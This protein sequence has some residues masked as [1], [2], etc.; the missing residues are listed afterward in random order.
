MRSRTAEMVK[1]FHV[2][3]DIPFRT[4]PELPGTFLSDARKLR[5][6]LLMEEYSEYGSAELFNDIVEI[7]DALGDMVYVIYGTALRYGID[8][9]AVL[10]EIHRSN[11]T[12]TANPDGGKVQKGEDFVPPDIQGVLDRQYLLGESDPDAPYARNH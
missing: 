7:A 2:Q 6:W 12:K 4:E 10:E 3:F 9:D 1:E 11:M 5:R 8:L